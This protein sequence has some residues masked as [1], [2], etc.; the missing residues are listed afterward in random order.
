M[1]GVPNAAK[2]LAQ[3]LKRGFKGNLVVEMGIALFR[4]A[5]LLDPSDFEETTRLAERV[6]NREMPAEFLSA[7]DVFLSKYSI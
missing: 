2:A 7:W 6:E 1:D 3:K 4:L 5:K